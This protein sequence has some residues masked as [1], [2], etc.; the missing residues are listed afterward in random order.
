VKI[1]DANSITKRS[2]TT[3]EDWSSGASTA[4]NQLIPIVYHQLRAGVAWYLRRERLDHTLRPTPL[5][6]ETYLRLI[7]HAT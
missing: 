7:Q 6:N 2:T 5:V 4:L 3:V 1:A